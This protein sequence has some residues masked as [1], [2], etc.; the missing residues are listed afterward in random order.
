MS[1]AWKELPMSPQY[2]EEREKLPGDLREEFDALVKW[3]RYYSVLHY[4]QPFVSYKVLAGLI[5]SGWR[6][7]AAPI[8]RA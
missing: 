4:R 1:E 8:D 2:L 6:L 7:S 5:R 3:Y